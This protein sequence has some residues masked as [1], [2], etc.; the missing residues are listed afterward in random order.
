MFK[1][2]PVWWISFV[3]DGKRY[4][5]SSGTANRKL[6][7]NIEDKIKGDI[8]QGKWFERLP[9]EEKLFEEMMQK[10]LAE[11]ASKK[12]S[13]R[14]FAGYAKTLTL[15]F[16]GLIV[17]DITPKAINQYKIK[18]REDGVKPATIN[19]ELAAM[20]KAFNLA[21]KE[22]E[23]VRENPVMKV[24]MEVENNKRERWLKDDEE[25]R[26]LEACPG[27]LQ[28]LVVFAL[29]TGMRLSEILELKWSEVDFSRMTV[30]VMR[31]K[32]GQ[33]RTIPLNETAFE[34]LRAKSVIRPITIEPVFPSQAWTMLSRYNVSRAFRNVVGKAKIVDFHFHDLRHTF[35]TRLVQAGK[36]L[37][38]VQIL[39][40]HKTAAMTQRYAHHYPESLRDAVAALDSG[41]WQSL[42]QFSHSN[43]KGATLIM[44][45]PLK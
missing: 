4:R 23:W 6:A 29:N 44:G 5:Q 2:G 18:R 45:N 35:A 9:G 15:F 17:A 24:S 30:T 7:K 40:G 38:K 13:A 33:K 1:R 21:L 8:V 16:G 36:D 42:S 3:Y 28:E 31:S 41:Q 12:A 14:D 26:L 22:W 25:K 27:W 11:H 32:N 19:R 43:K 20:K 37:Y 10:Y 34:M 39:L